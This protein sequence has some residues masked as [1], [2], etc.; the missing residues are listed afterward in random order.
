MIMPLKEGDAA[1][2]VRR[3]CEAAIEER[4]CRERV[5]RV[6]TTAEEQTTKFINKTIEKERY[7]SVSAQSVAE[8]SNVRKVAIVANAI[9]QQRSASPQSAGHLY[10]ADNRGA[11]MCRVAIH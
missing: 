7:R 3:I 6:K 2:P 10:R 4:H 11:D 5:E 1:T 8:A 9:R